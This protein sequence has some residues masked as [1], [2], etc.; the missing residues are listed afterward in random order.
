MV[1]T[2]KSYPISN[3][4]SRLKLLFAITGGCLLYHEQKQLMIDILFI[5]VVQHFFLFLSVITYKTLFFIAISVTF[6][7]YHIFKNKTDI[8]KAVHD[9]FLIPEIYHVQLSF[10]IT[11]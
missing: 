8:Y 2:K 10:L 3:L 9:I 1:F 11:L 5:T 6:Y 4:D 7:F